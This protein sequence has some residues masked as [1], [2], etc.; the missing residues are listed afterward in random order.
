MYIQ[1]VEDDRHLGGG[2]RVFAFRQGLRSLQFED[3]HDLPVLGAVGGC[4]GE[5]RIAYLQ[6]G[7]DC[8]HEKRVRVGI[9]ED[10]VASGL[11]NLDPIMGGKSRS[12]IPDL[13][14]TPDPCWLAGEVQ[15]PPVEQRPHLL[16]SC[17]DDKYDVITYVKTS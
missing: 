12:V 13:D 15:R 1:L 7:V 2:E 8:V 16:Q 17:Y 9:G 14:T 11:N 6:Q 3:V 5:A 4:S 10:V